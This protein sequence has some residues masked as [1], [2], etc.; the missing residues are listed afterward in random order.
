MDL[1]SHT[2]SQLDHPLVRASGC[3]NDL[4]ALPSPRTPWLAVERFEC[5]RFDERSAVLQLLGRLAGGIP[6]PID[7]RLAVQIEASKSSYLAITSGN[8]E[9]ANVLLWQASFAVPLEVVEYPHA[10][11]T[12]TADDRVA[13]VQP[14]DYDF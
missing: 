1:F 11:F 2:H 12:L 13:A 5:V 6:A 14:S 8:R 7:A 3:S 4:S 9:R 10:L